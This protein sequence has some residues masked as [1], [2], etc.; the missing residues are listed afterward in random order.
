MSATTIS[1]LGQ[2]AL[3][4]SDVDRSVAFYRDALGLPFLFSA[5]P[6]LAFLDLG[7]VRLMLTAP[8]GDFTPGMS[9][10]LYLVVEDIVAAHAEYAARGMTFI[11]EPHL[12][13]PMPDHDLWMCFFK[14]PDQHM[15]A[16]M[17]MRAKA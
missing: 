12:I 5:G 8:E 7:G 14:D 3:T 11:D 6:G 15:L 16:L 4:V 2:I 9:S 13:A 10:V 17:C 1:A